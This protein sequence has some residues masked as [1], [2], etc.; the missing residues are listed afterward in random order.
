V[1]LLFLGIKMSEHDEQ[2][3]LFDW[4]RVYQTEIPDLAM[5]FSIPNQGG[6]GK[7][8]IIRGRKM[9]KEGLKSGVPDVFLAVSRGEHHGMFVEMKIKGGK[10][11]PNQ[12]CWLNALTLAG[13]ICVVVY[14]FEQ[15]KDAIL[16][17]IQGNLETEVTI[18][19]SVISDN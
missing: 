18:V 1:L 5:M 19:E 16:D 2:V 9:V 10:V 12:K 7:G 17:Y 6:S 13:Y 14:T 11:S 15:A 8:A 4:A 3:A